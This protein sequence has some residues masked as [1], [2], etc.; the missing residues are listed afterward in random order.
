[1]IHAYE[2]TPLGVENKF[3]VM[4]APKFAIS[5]IVAAAVFLGF[6]RLSKGPENKV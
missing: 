6:A 3:G 5:Y 2:L 4:A 1:V